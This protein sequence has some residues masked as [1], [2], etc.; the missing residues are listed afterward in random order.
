MSDSN[1]VVKRV[2]WFLI[3][4][5]CATLTLYLVFRPK[6]DSI[7]DAQKKVNETQQK[8]I[9]DLQTATSQLTN[10]L[11]DSSAQLAAC[12]AKFERATILYDVG[13]LGES[14]TWVVP[15]DVEPLLAAGKRGVFSHYDPKTQ[16][17]TVKFRPKVR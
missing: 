5:A 7:F 15:A 14:R 12:N 4:F 8:T 3:G 6:E 9:S 16:T 1:P 17:E 11:N 2:F 13:L 10:S